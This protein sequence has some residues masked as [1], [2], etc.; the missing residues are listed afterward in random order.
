MFPGVAWHGLDAVGSF[1]LQRFV[2]PHVAELP[3]VRLVGMSHYKTLVRQVSPVL[4][5]VCTPAGIDAT[6]PLRGEAMVASPSWAG[7]PPS[8][9]PVDMLP[10]EVPELAT[11]LEERCEE[12]CAEVDY[13]KDSSHGAR[14]MLVTRK[15]GNAFNLS[16]HSP[17]KPFRSAW[18]DR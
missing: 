8:V 18:W 11:A 3:I 17:S 7:R 12:L 15:I 10:L 13:W 6:L 5:F 14:G 9:A 4:F 2:S 16:R 1:G